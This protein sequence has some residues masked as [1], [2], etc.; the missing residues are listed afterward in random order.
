MA[1]AKRV[2]IVDDEEKVVFFLRES[3]EELGP[4]LTI[5]TA[6]SAEEALAEIE[7]HP[8]DLVIS[9]LR[10]PGLDGLD[11]LAAVKQRYP[12]T[13]FILMTAY[14]SDDVAARAQSLEAY[15][16]ITKPFH[17]SDLLEA[18]RH[19]LADVAQP[20]EEATPLADDQS[21]EMERALSNLRFEVGAQCAFLADMRGRIISEVGLMH[22]LDTGTFI[23]LVVKGRATSSDMAEYLQD[24]EIFNLNVYEGKNYDIY[25]TTLGDN[26]FLTLVFDRRKQPSRI[27]MVWLY[28]KR[29]TQDLLRALDAS[30]EEEDRTRPSEESAY[31]QPSPTKPDNIEETTA[32]K[33][34]IDKPAPPS[35]DRAAA[36][37]TQDSTFGIEEA[38]RKGLID[39]EFAQLLKGEG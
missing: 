11:L 31:L 7:S 6:G 27:G 16:Y 36:G 33:A 35:E 14:G 19:A 39:E 17:V 28:V 18:A 15:H 34:T 23:P 26:R 22:G 4:D 2:L 13:R 32:V 30:K 1:M 5:G 10:M 20:E 9:D 24:E 25:S 29:A 8:Y 12:N 21:E 37:P 3:L 38:L